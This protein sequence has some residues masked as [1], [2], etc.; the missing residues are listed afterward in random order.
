M[1]TL[2]LNS[3]WLP[4]LGPLAVL[5]LGS[6]LPATSFAQSTNPEPS[7]EIVARTGG[8]TGFNSVAFTTFDSVELL[9]D[10]GTVIFKGFTDA[11]VSGF[12]EAARGSGLYFQ[13]EDALDT[14]PPTPLVNTGDEAP[15]VT[16]S[17]VTDLFGHV[18]NGHWAVNSSGF[19]AFDALTKDA[20]GI[21]TIDRS[22][23]FTRNGLGGTPQVLT[24]W[25]LGDPYGYNSITIFDITTGESLGGFFDHAILALGVT[26]AADVVIR[27]DFGGAVPDGGSGQETDVKRGIYTR[28]V[29]GDWVAIIRDGD[30]AP[31]LATGVTV[32]SVSQLT[33]KR[34]SDVV[35]TTDLSNGLVAF[36]RFDTAEKTLS[37]IASDDQAAPGFPGRDWSPEPPILG[38][39]NQIAFHGSATAT[40]ETDIEAIWLVSDN[41][42]ETLLTPVMK[43]A[44]DGSII[45]QTTQGAMT[46][47]SLAAPLLGPN[48]HLYF[49]PPLATKATRLS[50]ASGISTSASRPTPSTCWW[51][52]TP[53]R[54]GRASRPTTSW[55]PCS[56]G[57]LLLPR[58]SSSGTS[59]SAETCCFPPRFTA[60][61]LRPAAYG[62]SMPM[63]ASISWPR[64]A[65]R[66]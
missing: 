61:I 62:S 54:R 6:L 41:A 46:F 5:A 27:T 44:N 15:G 65:T 29:D 16:T 50:P 11:P 3:R 38:F 56:L 49:L 20:A 58:T 57:A 14:N 1:K 12:A 45:T 8:P 24:N 59:M 22:T 64:R 42:G 13:R 55:E 43:A 10:T 52:P 63:A 30:Q 33:S 9:S 7:I 21:R 2:S 35:L 4:A 51:P 31:G 34:S 39:S 48:D 36:W 32:T 53:K 47:R 28:A 60:A 17:G 18:P 23:V 25:R 26:E 40:G 19:F 37:L 66:G